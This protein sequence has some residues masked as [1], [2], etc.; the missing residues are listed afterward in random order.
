MLP[1]AP[2]S[3]WSARPLGSS[4]I[5]TGPM[6]TVPDDESAPRRV[7]TEWV[8]SLVSRQVTAEA[9][10]REAAAHALLTARVRDAMLSSEELLAIDID[11]LAKVAVGV[12]IEFLRNPP[13][14]ATCAVCGDT[15]IRDGDKVIRI[16]DGE[17]L[18]EHQENAR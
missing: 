7:Y 18:C 5:A 13:T 16:D 17:G 6:L 8:N 15:T 10:E 9:Q 3:G 11:G 4:D 12:F 2:S 14:F 1:D